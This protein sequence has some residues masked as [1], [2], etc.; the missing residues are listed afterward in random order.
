GDGA[1]EPLVLV[2]Q[3]KSAYSI[4]VADTASSVEKKA[5]TEF[6]RLFALSTGIELPIIWDGPPEGAFE[7]L[8]GRVAKKYLE[9]EAAGNLGVDGFLIKSKKDLLLI[10]GGGGKGVLYGVY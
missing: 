4:V 3:G 1:N 10:N 6:Q 9:E 7:I 2:A 5:A 8:I